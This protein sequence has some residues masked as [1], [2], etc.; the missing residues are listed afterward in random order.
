MDRDS[1]EGTFIN[2]CLDDTSN[3]PT[4]QQDAVKEKQK[5][6]KVRP[7]WQ[8]QLPKYTIEP[9]RE[10]FKVLPKRIVRREF[11]GAYSRK[12]QRPRKFRGIRRF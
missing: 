6:E 11:K 9:N 12:S 7:N 10:L 8:I 4:V 1:T 5:D 2:P 3:L